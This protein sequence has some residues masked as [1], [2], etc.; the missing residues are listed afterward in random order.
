[1]TII[2]AVTTWFVVP[3]SIN[4]HSGSARDVDYLGY[5]KNITTIKIILMPL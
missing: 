3:E 1:M 5:V 2:V 4:V